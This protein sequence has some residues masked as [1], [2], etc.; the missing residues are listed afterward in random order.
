MKIKV[1]K[2]R[3]KVSPVKTFFKKMSLVRFISKLLANL[4]KNPLPSKKYRVI[5]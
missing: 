4:I 3:I 5:D 1:K 2:E